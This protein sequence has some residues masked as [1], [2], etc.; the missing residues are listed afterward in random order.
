MSIKSLLK[1]LENNPESVEFDQVVAVI[2]ENYDYKATRFR[3]GEVINE[4]GTNEGS[5]K[6]FAFG[7]L[8]QLS[9]AQMLACFG[10]Y[11]R[12]DVLQNPEGEDHANIRGFMKTGWEGIE[13]DQ[14]ALTPLSN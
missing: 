1:V 13:F 10:N 9:V 7:L 12:V 3:N 2:A 11:Y 14:Q 4:A 5:C 6:L 8:N